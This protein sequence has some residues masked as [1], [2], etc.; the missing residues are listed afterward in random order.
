MKLD[1]A[2]KVAWS[3]TGVNVGKADTS[4]Q[5]P[6]S[7]TT[8]PNGDGTGTIKLTDAAGQP[9]PAY[10]YVTIDGGSGFYLLQMNRTDRN[11]SFGS[12]RAR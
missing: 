4:G 2:G 9:G 12:G 3:I 6:V 10:A 11:A 1:G 5:A 7:K 8:R